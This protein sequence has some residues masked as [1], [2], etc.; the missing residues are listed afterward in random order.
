MFS[1]AI[2]HL[3]STFGH[4]GL[5]RGFDN[6]NKFLSFI[7]GVV[8]TQIGSLNFSAARLILVVQFSDRKGIFKVEFVAPFFLLCRLT[9]FIFRF[10]LICANTL[11]SY[12]LL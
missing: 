9:Y 11:L 7:P 10:C 5:S 4:C 2:Q 3:Q 8:T 1:I 12:P 6:V